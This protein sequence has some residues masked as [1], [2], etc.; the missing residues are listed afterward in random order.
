MDDILTSIAFATPDL[1][2]NEKI[3]AEELIGEA[4]RQLETR[5]L[6]LTISFILLTEQLTLLNEF[7]LVAS[8]MQNAYTQFQWTTASEIKH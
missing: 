3:L 5:N 6:Q 4:K 7:F 8:S 1:C 2:T